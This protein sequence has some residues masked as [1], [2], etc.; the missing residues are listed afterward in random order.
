MFTLDGE[1]GGCISNED[2][3]KVTE[4]FE[5]IIQN[6]KNDLVWL[7]YYQDQI[8]QKFRE[9]ERFISNMVLKFHVSKST[10]AFK[11]ALKILINDF[12][13]IKNSLK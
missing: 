4:D 5:Q 9:K 8:F 13:K 6:K 10:M 11:I 3:I 12:P 1:L 7:A 2:A